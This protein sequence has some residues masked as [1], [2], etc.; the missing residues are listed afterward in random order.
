MQGFHLLQKQRFPL[1]CG[2]FICLSQV[3][4]PEISPPPHPPTLLAVSGMVLFALCSCAF[5]S[6]K[7]GKE[8]ECVCLIQLQISLCELSA[9]LQ[10]WTPSVL[11]HRSEG[12]QDK[13]KYFRGG[14]LNG[15]IKSFLQERR[16]KE[17]ALH[18]RWH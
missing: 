15:N 14:Y 7:K 1:Q 10:D 13:G 18:G 11:F 8:R 12:P 6:Q 4:S 17:W 3:S 5:N 2:I 16:E 9:I